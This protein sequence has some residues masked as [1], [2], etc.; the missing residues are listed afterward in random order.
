MTEVWIYGVG[1]IP[2]FLNAISP[3]YYKD[4]I[5]D[6]VNG[7]FLQ[8]LLICIIILGYFLF[9]RY[10]VIGHSKDLISR[11]KSKGDFW[12]H[13]FSRGLVIFLG[14][15]TRLMLPPG[16]RSTFLSMFTLI[17]IVLFHITNHLT[18]TKEQ[19]I[20]LFISVFGFCA[21]FY[22][23][24]QTEVS[25]SNKWTV[26][27]GSILNI[28]MLILVA[29]GQLFVK[30]LHIENPFDD[31]FIGQVLPSIVIFPV[32]IFYLTLFNKWQI[33]TPQ[34][35]AQATWVFFIFVFIVALIGWFFLSRISLKHYMYFGIIILYF[36]LLADYLFKGKIPTQITFIFITIITIGYLYT[37]YHTPEPPKKE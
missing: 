10:D 1:L 37:I 30:D 20:G 29:Y 17:F 21:Y 28:V 36:G 23:Y 9:R 13:C 34:E 8:N 14:Y 19:L 4:L 27:A 15:S 2:S 5:F 35:Y 3:H 22:S 11:F 25:P 18:Y 24:Y 7:T 12:F 26:F 31:V 33:G 32:A 16:V 6:S